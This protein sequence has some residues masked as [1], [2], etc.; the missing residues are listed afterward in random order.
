MKVH[1]QRYRIPQSF[2]G[3]LRF[4]TDPGFG[5]VQCV[6]GFMVNP[7]TVLNTGDNST[8]SKSITIGHAGTSGS[9][10]SPTTVTCASGIAHS[11]NLASTQ[12]QV[13]TRNADW[14]TSDSNRGTRYR[15]TNFI[16]GT[17]E[18]TCNNAGKASAGT[19][20]D[21]I[22]M[23]MFGGTGLSSATNYNTINQTQNA[24]R[25]ITGLTFQP[26]VVIGSW[27]GDNAG[28]TSVNAQSKLGFGAVGRTN[29]SDS[30]YIIYSGNNAVTPVA[31]KAGIGT[32]MLWK[33]LSAFGTATNTASAASGGGVTAFNADG[34][35]VQTY[36]AAQAASTYQFNFTAL[37]C[38]ERIKTGYF[39]T[40]TGTGSTFVNLG[41]V[42]QFVM[43]ASCGSSIMQSQPETN[44]EAP[45]VNL[46][47]AQGS[48][49]SKF[50]EG[51]GT[52]TTSTANANV[53]G[54]GSSFL[55]Q[56]SQ[57]DSIYDPTYQF[58]GTV[59][60]VASTTSMAFTGNAS[61]TLTSQNYFITRTTNYTLFFGDQ[62]GN[63]VQK[64]FCGIAT[65]APSLNISSGT[66]ISSITAGQVITFTGDNSFTINYTNRYGYPQLNWYMA[67]EAEPR[68][69]RRQSG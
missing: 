5:Q 54:T 10:V 38:N 20:F 6:L 40:P 2:A 12:C 37:Q 13:G 33:R 14:I 17:D 30:V 47:F 31:C 52:I 65:S 16:F 8:N 42:P 28:N 53:T 24:L 63:S 69:K 57:G 9:S 58:V 41:F 15:L 25:N 35:D 18:I 48:T 11:N 68:Q 59:A 49:S 62:V 66:A 60:S 19:T 67:I 56:I 26:D 55:A 23:V 3:N 43:G 7:G 46:W 61:L 1:L 21:D 29:N 4:L 64:G 32:D 36:N 50:I 44:L 22:I 45:S 51:K 27:C 39:F 34:F